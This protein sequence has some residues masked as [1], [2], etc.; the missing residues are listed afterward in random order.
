[1]T[2]AMPGL[3][4]TAQEIVLEPGETL[5]C[6][7]DG[8]TEAANAQGEEFSEER[9]QDLVASHA[10]DSLET[11]LDLV[12]REV[13]AFTGEPLEDDFTLLAVR[14]PPIS[15]RDQPSPP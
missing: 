11:L 13:S 8:A 1:M 2:G 10:H 14:R 3:R 9:L 6:F 4:Y 7:T 15:G 5:V 12:H